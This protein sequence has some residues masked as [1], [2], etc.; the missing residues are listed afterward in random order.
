MIVWSVLQTGY[1]SS[2]GD[3]EPNVLGVYSTYE[4]AVDATKVMMVDALK[5]AKFARDDIEQTVDEIRDMSFED[6]HDMWCDVMEVEPI[7]F[8]ER[9]LD[10]SCLGLGAGPLADGT[11]DEVG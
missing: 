10:A 6:L 9:A 1:Y 3:F 4:K 11:D 7:Q 5:G 2:S 8:I